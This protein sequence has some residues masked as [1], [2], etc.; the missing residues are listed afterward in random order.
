M[1]W[2]P[3]EV[4]D[5]DLRY[6]V[7]GSFLAQFVQGHTIEDVLRELVQN[8]YDAG[9]RSLAVM[10]REDGLYVDGDGRTIDGGGWR[11]LSVMVGTGQVV[12]D[13]RDVPQKENGIGSKNHG[14]RSL[15]LIGDRIYVRSGGRQTV[16]DIHQGAYPDPIADAVSRGRPGAHIFVPFRSVN[17]GLL[18]EYGL[19]RQK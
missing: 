8:E 5:S 10:F 11:R 14:L 4:D 16:L 3:P 7:T 2:Q 15:F 12:G 1:E 9:G 6:A 19:A 18:E 13:G 17:N